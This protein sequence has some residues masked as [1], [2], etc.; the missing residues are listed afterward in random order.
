MRRTACLSQSFRTPA[1]L[2][3]ASSASSARADPC[4][5]SRRPRRPGLPG[6]AEEF[7]LR[8]TAQPTL[9]DDVAFGTAQGQTREALYGEPAAPRAEPSRRVPARNEFRLIPVGS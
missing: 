1:R 4:A 8:A 2:S 3:I 9:Y 6:A 5:V 7:A